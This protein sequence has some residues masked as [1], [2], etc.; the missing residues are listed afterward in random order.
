VGGLDLAATTAD[1]EFQSSHRAGAFVVGLDGSREG[2]VPERSFEELN[3]I[4]AA[5]LDWLF[6]ESAHSFC[7]WLLGRKSD[8]TDEAVFVRREQ[9]DRSSESA[10][11][12]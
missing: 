4:G 5:L 6:R 2:S 11:V 3:P 1:D 10:L 9:A 8:L 12:R 7:L